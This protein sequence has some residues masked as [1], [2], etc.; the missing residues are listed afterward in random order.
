MNTNDGQ[1]RS[2]TFQIAEPASIDRLI[3]ENLASLHKDGYDLLS[4]PVL[5]EKKDGTLWCTNVYKKRSNQGPST[6]AYGFN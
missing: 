2:K 1:F 4:G 5:V 6:G 3:E